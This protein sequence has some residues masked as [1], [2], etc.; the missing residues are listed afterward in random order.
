MAIAAAQDR[1]QR[2]RPPAH[3]FDHA[4]FAGHQALICQSELAQAIILMR[5]DAS[6][7]KHQIRADLFQ[8]GS[9]MMIQRPQIGCI[10]GPLWKGD[11]Q[12]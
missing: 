9:Q 11:I 12:V 2:N 6:D 4:S 8:K 1:H 7:V 5:I 10:A 3:G